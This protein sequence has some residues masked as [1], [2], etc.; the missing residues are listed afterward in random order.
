MISR[1]IRESFHAP[2]LTALLVAAGTTIGAFWIQDLR[3]DVFPDLSAPI[4]NVIT[5]N[6]AMGAEEL[7]TAIAIPLEVALA[8]LES[9]HI[10]ASAIH[11]GD[12]LD[13]RGVAIDQVLVECDAVVVGLPATRRLGAF[14]PELRLPL[15]LLF[16]FLGA[17]RL[18]VDF[19]QLVVGFPVQR[20][21]PV[22]A[23]FRG[24]RLAARIEFRPAVAVAVAERGLA[25]LLHAAM[26]DHGHGIVVY[27]LS[28]AGVGHE[29]RAPNLT[30]VGL[31]R[32]SGFGSRQS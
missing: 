11:F 23:F 21:D 31:R 20:I 32:Q 14:F 8:G 15:P 22:E 9:Q 5:Q 4:F 29:A 1:L 12:P 3:R 19:D 28:G 6:P 7:E 27:G 25:P 2:L 17:G 13:S 26:H 10:G 16:P 24:G 30:A 18:S